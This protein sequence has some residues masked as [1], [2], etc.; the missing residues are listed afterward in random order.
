MIEKIKKKKRTV[1]AMSAITRRCIDPAHVRRDTALR[2]TPWKG[3]DTL[4]RY[5]SVIILI[6]TS[7]HSAT[8]II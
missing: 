6:I 3:S 5:G 7:A 2:A 8:V 4:S 1:R